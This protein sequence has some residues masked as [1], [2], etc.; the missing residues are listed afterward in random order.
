MLKWFHGLKIAHKLTLVSVIFVIP[1]SI[2]L[3]LFITSINEN[4][5]VARLEQTGNEYQR[6][7]EPL[8]KLIPEHRLLTRS[9]IYGRNNAE[10]TARSR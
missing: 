8:L 2:M 1:D 7:V 6:A 5:Q 4:I 9:D 10:V 3:Y